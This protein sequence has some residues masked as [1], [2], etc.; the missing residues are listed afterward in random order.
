MELILHIGAHRSASTA[1]EQCLSRNLSRLAGDGVQV[2][3]PHA[4]RKMPGF[5]AAP[6]LGEA[7]FAQA[8]A[9]FAKAVSASG[10]RKLV[11]SEENMLGAMDVNLRTGVLYPRAKERL[12]AY[13]AFF[14][15]APRRVALGIRSY[16]SFWLS[17]YLYVLR[18]RPLPPFEQLASA[19]ASLPRGWRDV[20]AD[21]RLVFP[22]AEICLWQMEALANRMEDVAFALVDRSAEGMDRLPGPVNAGL[23]PGHIPVIHELRKTDPGLGDVELDARLSGL[24]VREYQGFE[25]AQLAA[26]ASRYAEDAAAFAEGVGGVRFL[27]GPVL[28]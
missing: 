19:L 14:P 5:A 25:P 10:A 18:R 17:C 8:K 12:A 15:V 24:P 22:D 2:W 28:T 27:A 26:M 21:V 6:G 3:K 11:I 13:A 7:D 9:G 20:V 23:L 4:L 16:A 1:I